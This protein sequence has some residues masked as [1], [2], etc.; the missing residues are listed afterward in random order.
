M[1][2][3]QEVAEGLVVYQARLDSL[4]D[5]HSPD[6]CLARQ[7]GI[8]VE[9]DELDVLNIGESWVLLAALRVDEVLDFSHQ[10]LAD[11]K[12]TG[13]GRDL[14]AV[15]LA[16]GSRGE[17]HVA[18][19]EVEQLGKVEELALGSLRS[20]VTRQ[21]AAGTDGRLEHQVERNRRGG[22]DAGCRILKVVLLDQLAELLAAVVVD[23]GQDLLVLLDDR[24]VQLDGLL[25]LG[26]LFL[27]LG[28][29]LLLHDGL[30]ARLFVALQARFEDILHKVVSPEDLAVLGVLA[31]PV[32]ELV[33]V[34][35]GLEH[36]VG[37][38]DSAVDLEHVLLQDEMLPPGINNVRLQGATRWAVVVETGDATVD[39]EG[40]GIE[41]APA[42][43]GVEKSPVK[44]LALQRGS[45][46]RHLGR[47]LSDFETGFGTRG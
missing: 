35:A 26:L 10:E 16:N 28:V 6:R 37:G 9:K 33:H 5:S 7:L 2:A 22:L 40:G 27:L 47:K 29:L 46:R 43:H 38:Q 18:S 13:S 24:V 1:N 31:H 42:Q 12:Q 8:A 4:A 21:V 19:V 17:G 36:L 3:S 20:E 44:G 14:V 32:G 15:R 25:T 45:G 34:P 23:L 30:S 41:Q 11:A 39:F